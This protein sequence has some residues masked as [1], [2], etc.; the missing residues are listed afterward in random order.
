[1][2]KYKIKNLGDLIQFLKI[3]IIYNRENKRLWLSQDFYINKIATSFKIKDYYKVFTPIAIK[4]FKPNLK[5]ASK[6]D[7]YIY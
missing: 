2:K 5:Q 1:M 4:E 3:Q 6:Q 7:I